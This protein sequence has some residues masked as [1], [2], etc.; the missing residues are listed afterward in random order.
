MTAECGSSMARRPCMTSSLSS[1]IATLTWRAPGA[2]VR[3]MA[4]GTPLGE[5][6]APG[7]VL[8][9]QPPGD[10]CRLPLQDPRLLGGLA[11]QHFRVVGG[12]PDA[13]GDQAHRDVHEALLTEPFGRRLGSAE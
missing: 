2:C 10:R 3:S 6:H 4:S 13:R 9:E 1:M 5:E 7:F 12:H 11:Q 8:G